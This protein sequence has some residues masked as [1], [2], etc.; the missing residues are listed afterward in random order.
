MNNDGGEGVAGADGV[1]EV[2]DGRGRFFEA[3]AVRII[4]DGTVSS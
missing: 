2:G 3:S 4:P 1:G